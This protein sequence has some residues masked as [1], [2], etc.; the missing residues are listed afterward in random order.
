MPPRISRLEVGAALARLNPLTGND[1]F[2]D[3][4]PDS[5]GYVIIKQDSESTAQ[6]KPFGG[7]RRVAKQ[8]LDVLEFAIEA[9]KQEREMRNGHS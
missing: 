2:L 6:S 1:Y 4:Y 9:I 5:G 8:M 7:K 3:Y